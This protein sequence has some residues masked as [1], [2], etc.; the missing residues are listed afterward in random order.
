[1]HADS[2]LYQS[3][4]N[5]LNFYGCSLNPIFSIHPVDIDHS[6]ELQFGAD[7]K[8]TEYFNQNNF[9]EYS[10]ILTVAFDNTKR[11]DYSLSDD[12]SIISLSFLQFD[13]IHC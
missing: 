12:A 2:D 4:S 1:M 10:C 8:K 9:D 11:T 13:L 7:H 6:E 3:N 5:F